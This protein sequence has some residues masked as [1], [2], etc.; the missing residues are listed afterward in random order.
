MSE[1]LFKV[2]FRGE[3]GFEFEEEEVKANLQKMSGFSPEKVGMLFSGQTHVLKKDADADTAGRFRDA[4]MRVGALAAVEP[5]QTPPP[6]VQQRP[7]AADSGSRAGSISCPA[8]GYAQEKGEACVSCGIFFARYDAVQQRK[9]E[10]L[11]AEIAGESCPSPAVVKVRRRPVLCLDLRTSPSGQAL[12]V[13]AAVAVLQG[14]FSGREL[15]ATGFIALAALFVLSLIFFSVASG[16]D[17]LEGITDNLAVTVE[18]HQAVD[19]R[20]HWWPRKVTYGLVA[21]TILLYY[22]VT[23]HLP[24]GTMVDYLAFIPGRP[25]SWN[26]PLS[27]LAAPFLN[28]GGGQ[29]W[30]G[31]LFLWVTGM[32][33]EARL[34]SLWFFCCYLGLGVF[35]EV[36]GYL[37][38][39]LLF[40]AGLHGLGPSGAIAGLLGICI[41]GGL[42]PVLTFPFPL[43][44][45]LPLIYHLGIEVRF[46]C[47]A[48]LGFFI[49]AGIAAGFGPQHSFPAAMG[50]QLINLAGL[51]GGLLLGRLLPMR[52]AVVRVA[53]IPALDSAR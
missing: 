24:P 3:I 17:L 34:G 30:F 46:N 8:C 25:T 36:F 50:G 31:M 7:R 38:H 12:L 53:G 18:H 19:R 43:L 27:A 4:L 39:C 40:G 51:L 32:V 49:Y 48:L 44:G 47:L 2:V 28:A 37:L 45:A 10:A 26:V 11:K 29:L 6:A 41:A 35:A 42:G 33:L 9:A 20:R 5:M 15:E 23:I 21:G 13:A 1:N 16:G 52:D 22:V 14:Y